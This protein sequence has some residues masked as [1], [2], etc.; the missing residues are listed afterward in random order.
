[1]YGPTGKPIAS[2]TCDAWCMQRTEQWLLAQPRSSH[3]T[4]EA[5]GCAE[6]IVDHFCHCVDKI[7]IADA[8]ELARHKGN[9]KR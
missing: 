3:L 5:V 1:M 4:F 2:L 6:W 7:D 8:T 9:A